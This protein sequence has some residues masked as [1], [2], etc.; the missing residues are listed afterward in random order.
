LKAG[1]SDRDHLLETYKDQAAELIEEKDGAI[2]RATA[3]QEIDRE[4]SAKITSLQTELATLKHTCT[5]LQAQLQLA[6]RLLQRPTVQQTN[7]ITVS[8]IPRPFD[9]SAAVEQI[10]ARLPQLILNTMDYNGSQLVFFQGL[11]RLA[12]D[13]VVDKQAPMI[14]ARDRSRGKFG[15]LSADGGRRAVEDLPAFLRS[16]LLPPIIERIWPRARAYFAKLSMV[17][18]IRGV[19]TVAVKKALELTDKCVAGLDQS[20][21]L[22]EQL[23]KIVS[24]EAP[25]SKN[26]KAPTQ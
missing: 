8:G 5:S 21:I 20:D 25:S 7:I 15:I 4:K 22:C 10:E 11:A 12:A 16:E 3:M 24:K 14:E 19:P 17:E 23:T 2:R 9:A 18:D 6:E 26:V 1:I 13:T